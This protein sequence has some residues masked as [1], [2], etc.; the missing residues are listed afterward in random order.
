MITLVSNIFLYI[1]L[2]YAVNYIFDRPLALQKNDNRN[3]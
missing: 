3:I 2:L 1:V